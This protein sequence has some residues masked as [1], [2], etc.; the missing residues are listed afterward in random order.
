MIKEVVIP[1]IGENIEK[2]DVIEVLVKEGQSVEIDQPLI[3]FETDKAVVDIPSPA[4]GKLVKILVK[5]GDT[6][7]VGQAIVQIDTDSV[8]VVESPKQAAP[9]SP[10]IAESQAAPEPVREKVPITAP[11]KVSA[12]MKTAPEPTNMLP[13][14]EIE[15]ALIGSA[16]PASPTVRRLARELGA[17][18]NKVSG[19]GPGGRISE[20][21]VKAYVKRIVLQRRGEPAQAAG[22]RLQTLPD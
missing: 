2:G 19:S 15:P 17:D 18:I 14:I 22:V 8:G 3:E 21:D 16:A 11:Q 12:P 5:K 9:Q 7:K 1:D 20:D 10:A 4:K 6:I 13:D